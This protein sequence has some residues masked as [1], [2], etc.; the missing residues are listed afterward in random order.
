[1]AEVVPVAAEEVATV[2]E[3]A[4]AHLLATSTNLDVLEDKSEWLLAQASVFQRSASSVR[5]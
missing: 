4:V 1:M 2:M 5:M 3:D